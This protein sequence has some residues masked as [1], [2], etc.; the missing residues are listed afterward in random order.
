MTIEN[1]RV[2]HVCYFSP[3]GWI[4]KDII[5]TKISMDDTSAVKIVQPGTDV[6]QDAEFERQIYI[7]NVIEKFSKAGQQK[8]HHH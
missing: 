1:S 5:V 7:T 4:Q 6:L 8:F 2:S 3:Q